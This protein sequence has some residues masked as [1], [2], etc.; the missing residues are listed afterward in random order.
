MHKHCRL[1]PWCDLEAFSGCLSRTLNRTLARGAR[2]ERESL[3][4]PG[5]NSVLDLL[6][7]NISSFQA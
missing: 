6:L 7:K 2:V 1:L 5:A 4:R 3:Y